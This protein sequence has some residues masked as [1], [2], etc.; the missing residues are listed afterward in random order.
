[1]KMEVSVF[2]NKTGKI[3]EIRCAEGRPVNSGEVLILI[4]D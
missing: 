1:M 3:R 2:A 4:E